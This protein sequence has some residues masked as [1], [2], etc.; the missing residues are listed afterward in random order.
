MSHPTRRLAASAGLLALIGA[1]PLA[2]ARSKSSEDKPKKARGGGA[3]GTRLKPS[4]KTTY[5]NGDT[6]AER[7]RHED[8]R[9]L[10]ECRGRPNAGACLGYAN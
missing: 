7:Q 1:L 8:A 5:A 2:Q 4:P 10:R 3:R 9:L 6:P